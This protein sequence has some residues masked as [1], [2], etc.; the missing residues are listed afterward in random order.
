[1]AHLDRLNAD[2]K[3]HGGV[4]DSLSLGEYESPDIESLP[5]LTDVVEL[6]QENVVLSPI[7][8]SLNV[9]ENYGKGARGEAREDGIVALNVK[10]V[11]N[12]HRAIAAV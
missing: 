6:G 5:Q 1:M 12:A 10:V 11:E 8:I 2:D 9:P 4:E 7:E 3:D